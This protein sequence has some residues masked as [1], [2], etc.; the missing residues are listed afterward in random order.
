MKN[1][2]FGSLNNN[3]SDVC[4][5][6]HNEALNEIYFCYQSGDQFTAFPNANRCN[7]A[8]VYNYRSTHG[9]STICPMSQL[10]QTP[11]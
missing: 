9:H 5:V 10:A 6:L 7:R 8:A 2:I 3:Q 11:T 4:F 1:F